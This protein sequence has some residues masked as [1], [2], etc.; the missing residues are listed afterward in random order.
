MPNFSPLPRAASS[1]S[2]AGEAPVSAAD[3]THDEKDRDRQGPRD[4][5][6]PPR[7]QNRLIIPLWAIAVSAF[8]MWPFW[9]G[10]ISPGQD[11]AYMV[12]DMMIPYT[13]PVNDLVTGIAPGAPRALPQDAILAMLSPTI[14]ASVC[15]SWIMVLTSTIAVKF[16]ARLVERVANAPL[17]VQMAVS[18]FVVWNPYT[19]ER[20]LQGHWTLVAAM[21]CLPAVAHAAAAQLRGWKLLM[22]ATCALTPTGWMM[23]GI[24]ALAFDRTMTNRWVTLHA[25]LFLAMP[26]FLVTVVNSPQVLTNAA[27]AQVFAAR[28]EPG[29]GTLGALMGLGGMWNGDAIPDS[30]TAL[31]AWLSVLL[32]AFMLIGVSELWQVYPKV[33]CLTVGAIVLPF[34]FSTPPGVLL[35]GWL[36]QHIPGGGLVR[37]GQKFVALAVPGMALMLAVALRLSARWVAS[38]VKKAGEREEAALPW[39]SLATAA[40][41]VCTVPTLPA[42]IKPLEQRRLPAEWTQIVN[43]ISASPNSHTLLLPPGSYRVSDGIPV[44]SP[45]LKLLPGRPIDPG[46]LV[47]NGQIVDGDPKA[48][49]ILRHTMNGE[50]YLADQGVGWVIVDRNSVQEGVNMDGADELLRHHRL[51]VKGNEMELYRIANPQVVD[52]I[53]ST[54]PVT[55]GLL[56]YWIVSAL[57]VSISIWY[58]LLWMN[59]NRGWW[60]WNN[61]RGWQVRHLTQD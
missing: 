39:L 48:M 57:G 54:A 5:Q 10:L 7:A 45:A 32:F 14:P 52:A 1:D 20:L 15:A 46:F 61:L 41:I 51:V 26:W 43:A 9:K 2:T 36:T 60:R 55:V 47:V 12:R 34:L 49:T 21:W 40:L 50:D 11:Y 16:T 44:L 22:L 53:G 8:T 13:M 24:T 23:G 58:L 31:T 42:D 27:S 56:A 38:A 17:L 59:N 28:A 37:D 4:I 35:I 25:Q 6:H 19:I 29:V 3:S 30:R 33:T 18:L